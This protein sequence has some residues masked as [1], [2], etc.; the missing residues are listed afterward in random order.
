MLDRLPFLYAAIVLAELGYLAWRYLTDAPA[1]SSSFSINL[2]WV[3]LGSML[4]LLVYSVARRSKTLRRWARLSYWLHFH[5]FLACQGVLCVFFHCWH[6]FTKT[7]P[8]NLLNPAFLSGVGTAIIFFSGLFGRYLYSLLPRTLGGVQ[9][10]A[11]EVEA[12]LA[13][14]VDLPEPVRNLLAEQ[15][16]EP[17]GFFDVVRTDLRTRKALRE[18]KTI[19]LS[20]EQLDLARRRL[21]LERRKAALRSSERLFRLWIVLHRPTAGILYVVAFVHVAFAFMFSSALAS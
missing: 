20:H 1:S 11:K 19:G 21:R 16:A 6:L 13:A 8:T 18:L 5:I 12:E 7:T 10:E 3:G 9:M 17:H 14:G 15:V 2:G 4:A